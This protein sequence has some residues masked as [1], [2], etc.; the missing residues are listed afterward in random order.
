MV[1]LVIENNRVTGEERLLL[2]Q[3]QRMRDI[4]QGPD[5]ALWVVTD[6]ENGR[7]IRI[8]NR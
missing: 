1:R 3:H 5:G 7:L 4:V 2:D 6:A 8:G